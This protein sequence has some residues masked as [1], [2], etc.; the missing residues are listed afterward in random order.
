LTSF[1][2]PVTDVVIA[3][4][5]ALAVPVFG[6]DPTILKMLFHCQRDNTSSSGA[7]SSKHAVSISLSQ[8]THIQRDLSSTRLDQFS[9]PAG[10]DCG[11][12]S[13]GASGADEA[14]L[15]K[16]AKDGRFELEYDASLSVYDGSRKL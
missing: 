10:I 8:H 13:F 1:V 16:L 3:I 12:K 5:T 15:P 4:V 2:N 14:A 9:A 6:S 11:W 7:Q